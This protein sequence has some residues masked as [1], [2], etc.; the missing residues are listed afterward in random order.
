[1]YSNFK[2]HRKFIVCNTE[3]I[4]YMEVGESAGK[5]RTAVDSVLVVRAR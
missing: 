2:M 1:M 4:T 5:T 3:N